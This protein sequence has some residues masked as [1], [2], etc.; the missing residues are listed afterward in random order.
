[1]H[2]YV[3][4]GS[5]NDD[6]MIYIGEDPL[7]LHAWFRFIIDGQEF[8]AIS[9]QNRLRDDFY[10]FLFNRRIVL[11]QGLIEHLEF[12][13]AVTAKSAVHVFE[14]NQGHL[15]PMPVS[16][17]RRTAPYVCWV[18]IGSPTV[19][20]DAVGPAVD[21]PNVL[22]G[23]Y[24]KYIMHIQLQLS[25]IFHKCFITTSLCVIFRRTVLL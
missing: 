10:R 9:C 5:E 4:A 14:P 24:T 2:E 11:T 16:L 12:L 20:L 6:T 22:Q 18:Q 21:A 15:F 8:E 7:M 17:N 23:P 3:R 19:Y 13:R 25:I 1:M